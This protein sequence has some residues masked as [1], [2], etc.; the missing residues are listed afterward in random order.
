MALV[1]QDRKVAFAHE[2]KDIAHV[3]RRVLVIGRIG[4]DLAGLSFGGGAVVIGR[5]NTHGTI[6]ADLKRQLP[7]QFDGLPDERSQKGHLGH[8]CLDLRG[9]VMLFED[10]FQYSVQP[11]HAAADI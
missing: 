8:Q 1:D 9:V 6:A 11:R 7:A 10:V 2:V 3:Q 5:Q 4:T